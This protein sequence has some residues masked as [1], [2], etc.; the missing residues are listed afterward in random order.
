[1]RPIA[2]KGREDLD[3]IDPE[4]VRVGKDVIEL[5][6]SGMYVSPVTIYREYIQNA[7]DSID[8]ARKLG[9]LGA[10]EQGTV[11]ISFDHAA[12]SVT[13][14]DNGAG[15]TARNV[16]PFLL[17]IGGSTKR[18]SGARGFRGV[19][20]LSGL[21]YCRE[22]Q[23]RTKAAGETIATTVT[24]D[25]HA[26]RN[27]LADHLFK[28]DLRE[29][30]SDSVAVWR[31]EVDADDHFFEVRL[32]EIA[33]LRN[34]I[35]LNEQ[36]VGN[37]LSQV[38]PLPFSPDFSFSKKIHEHVA[39]HQHQI[40]ITLSVGTQ[41]IRRPYRDDF[42]MPGTPHKVRIAEVE[43]LEFPDF[44][45]E[46]GAIGWIAHHDY[47]RRVPDALCIGGL[48]ARSGDIQVGEADLF[49]D[50]F[51]EPRFN[52][53]TI[54]EIHILD[55]RIVPNGRRD[56]F[57]TNHHYYNLLVQLGPVAAKI[58]QRCRSASISRN[59]SQATANVISEVEKRIKEK[60]AFDPAELS[61]HKSALIR[62]EAKTKRIADVTA[63]QQIG[64]KLERLKAA[65]DKLVPKRGASVV[66]LDEAA[67]LVA[68]HVSN[69]EQARRLLE[70]L[71]R[72]CR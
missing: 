36:L 45:G 33:R 56:N 26:L 20:R 49:E 6:T 31:E 7:V 63:R 10:T 8:A 5:L 14:R 53:W 32:G 38:A 43:L 44:D 50:V 4:F 30:I 57:E 12:R 3:K 17:S 23:F 22:L 13:I 66:A 41:I 40:P 15:L 58:T 69:R 46:P 21:A 25:C 35:L 61:R 24:W 68:K 65:L 28:G 67:T 42:T 54:G 16:L 59:A 60:R 34:D 11:T 72:L 64:R 55:R 2:I 39:K 52:G 70:E 37:Y 1:M 62:A 19:G 27:R 29:T 9:L 47:V 71:R 48:R 51:R 18:G